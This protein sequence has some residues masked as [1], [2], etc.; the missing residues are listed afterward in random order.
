MAGLIVFRS[1][2]GPPPANPW[3]CRNSRNPEMKDDYSTRM[4]MSCCSGV[5]LSGADVIH[6]SFTCNLAL[7]KP[8]TFKIPVNVILFLTLAPNF[9]TFQQHI[10]L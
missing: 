1:A 10:N 4:S 2:S 6:L 5:R 3:K 9:R 7:S 8:C